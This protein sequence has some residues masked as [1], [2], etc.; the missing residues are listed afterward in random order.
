MTQVPDIEPTDGATAEHYVYAPGNGGA[1]V[2]LFKVINGAHT[3]PGAPLTIDVTCMDFSASKEIWRFFSQFEHPTA[4]IKNPANNQPELKIWP[5]PAEEFIFIS[6]KFSGEGH[7]RILDMNGR[8]VAS[9][10]ALAGQSPIYVSHLKSG[11]YVLE[12]TEG[13][14]VYR[15]RWIKK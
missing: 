14:Q 8:T 4:G 13:S 10:T 3:W 2:E 9:G 6:D 15:G 1:T 7:Y 5:N 12:W 11:L